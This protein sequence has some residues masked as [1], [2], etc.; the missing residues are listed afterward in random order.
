MTRRAR[1]I[2]VAAV[3]WLALFAW[4]FLTRNATCDQRLNLFA[5]AGGTVLVVV[6]V[7]PFITAGERSLASRFGAALAFAV[8]TVAV[9]LAAGAAAD[10]RLMCRLF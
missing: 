7:V 6:V 8:V 9:W 4:P 10:V 5:L 3:L 2:A 1:P